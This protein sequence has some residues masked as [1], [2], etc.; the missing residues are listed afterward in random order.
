MPRLIVAMR[1]F[2]EA[3]RW[4]LMLARSHHARL[5]RSRGSGRAGRLG[6]ELACLSPEYRDAHRILLEL[7][8]HAVRCARLDKVE[9]R[10]VHQ[11]MP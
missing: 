8:A 9:N 10:M 6:S 4:R 1:W 3:A 7:L 11:E 5:S 2:G